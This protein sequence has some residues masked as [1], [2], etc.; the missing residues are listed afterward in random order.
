M[1]PEESGGQ[2]PEDHH[3]ILSGIIPGDG[4]FSHH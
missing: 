1:K 2:H 3:H 4:T